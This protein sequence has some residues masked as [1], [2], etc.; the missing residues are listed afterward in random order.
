MIIKELVPIITN[1]IIKDY[2]YANYVYSDDKTLRE[3]IFG[4]CASHIDSPNAIKEAYNVYI[5]EQDLID[6]MMYIETEGIVFNSIKER[7]YDKP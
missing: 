2:E 3:D 5:S 1:I 4:L 6:T 7:M